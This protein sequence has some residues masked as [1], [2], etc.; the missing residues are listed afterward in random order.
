MF[1]DLKDKA[2][3]IDRKRVYTAAAALLIAG[4]AGHFM[5]RT[6]G[7]GGSPDMMSAAIP[8]VSAPEILA[9]PPEAT[10]PDTVAAA[11]VPDSLPGV[12]ETR[13]AEDVLAEAEP[14]APEIT[15][16]EAEAELA[17]TDP[18]PAAEDETPAPV[19]AAA[20]AMVRP[21]PK[22]EIIPELG[23][24]STAIYPAPKAD[25]LL[26]EVTRAATDPLL[27]ITEPTPERPLDSVFAA[28]SDPLGLPP[29]ATIAP[30]E[31]EVAGC[32]IDVQGSVKAG[33]L[34]ELSITAPCNSGESVAFEHAGLKFSE[35]LGPDGSLIVEVPAMTASARVALHFA[36][37]ADKD[38]ELNVPDFEAFD[39]IAVIW[40]GATGLQ[41]HALE[42]GAGYDEAGHIWADTPGTPDAAIKETG[43]F[44]SVLGS[45]ASG[46]AA[47]VYTYPAGLMR[48]GIEPEVSIE[49]QVME[50]TCGGEIEGWIL[51]TNPGRAPNVEPLKIMVPGCEAVG[52]FLVLRNL[53]VELKLARR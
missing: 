26:E 15:A 19:I 17:M 51:R 29:T 27:T 24:A 6:S 25:L 35:Q 34:M 44:I 50:H 33:A 13:P 1:A 4:A 3:G 7:G 45:T 39:R 20:P 12:V 31:P 9:A 23:V 36:D 41:L 30:A 43:G 52:E 22:P 11:P 38:V 37:G 10:P 48:Q 2:A 42:G 53:P 8:A 49:A 14:A 28:A 47:D 18:A 32:A 5:Q 40:Q 21:K 46:F 16:P